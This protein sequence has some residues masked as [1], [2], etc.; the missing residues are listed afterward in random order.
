MISHTLN[1]E[2]ADVTIIV[3][4]KLPEITIMSINVPAVES[5]SYIKFLYT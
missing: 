2:Q 1:T 4:T 5:C 3:L